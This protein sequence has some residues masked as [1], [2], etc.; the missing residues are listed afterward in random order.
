MASQKLIDYL[1]E[2]GVKYSVVS[3]SRAI[4]ASEIAQ[5]IHISGHNL[6]KTVIVKADGKLA[7]AVLPATDQVHTGQLAKDL[8]TREVALAGEDEFKDRFPD[9]EVG[10]MPPF[11]NLYDM[12]VFVSPH[13]TEDELIAFNAGT[14]DEVV[15]MSYTVFERLVNP[16]VLPF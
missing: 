1:D 10:A 12:D 14:H 13:L 16:V 3:H 8:G 2:Q 11:G 9:C 5:A 4:T 15:Q 7:M 6:A